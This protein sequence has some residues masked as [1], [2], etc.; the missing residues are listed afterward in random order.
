LTL[1]ESKED[2]KNS[3]RNAQNFVKFNSS[4][5]GLDENVESLGLFA[6]K[7]QQQQ[8]RKPEEKRENKHEYKGKGK[9]EKVVIQEED[10]P[11]L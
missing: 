10:F 6:K 4:K 11:A 9:K 1:I 7:E 2:K 5:V 3:E 8:Q